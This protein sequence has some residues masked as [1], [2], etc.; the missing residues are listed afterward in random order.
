[1]C[2]QR[3]NN[4]SWKEKCCS[5]NVFT[6]CYCIAH[7]FIARENQNEPD[8]EICVQ[9]LLSSFREISLGLK[10]PNSTL[11]FKI[12]NGI[13]EN[14]DF[15]KVLLNVL[16]QSMHLWEM[17][18]LRLYVLYLVDK[19]EHGHSLFW[20]YSVDYV[21]CCFCPVA[22]C[23]L[24]SLGF[25]HF[26]FSLFRL[27]RKPCS[28][29]DEETCTCLELDDNSVISCSCDV[30]WQNSHHQCIITHDAF[31]KHEIW[32]IWYFFIWA[33]GQQTPPLYTLS[34]LSHGVVIDSEHLLKCVRTTWIDLEN[35]KGLIITVC[36]FKALRW[37]FCKIFDKEWNEVDR[38][39]MHPI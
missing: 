34:L 3:Q 26:L 35:N 8:G 20:E 21:V 5:G 17:L 38:Y 9:E 4:P 37:C 13:Y 30:L 32:N 39:H 31:Y 33:F 16:L 1:M 7:I 12:S 22:H 28:S 15:E 29:S 2:N 11:Q 24:V 18:C 36:R 6:Q 27:V 19:F 25:N 10:L 23:W 14:G